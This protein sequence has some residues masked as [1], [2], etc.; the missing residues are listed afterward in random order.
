MSV[1]INH[2]NKIK[3][4]NLRALGTSLGDATFIVI[5]IVN[6]SITHNNLL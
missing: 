2:E 4:I 1:A 5:I 6:L 3:K